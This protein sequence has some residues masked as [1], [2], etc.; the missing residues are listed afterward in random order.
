MT[1]PKTSV[2]EA[3]SKQYTQQQSMIQYCTGLITYSCVPIPERYDIT[4]FFFNSQI[5]TKHLR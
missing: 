3:N 4:F 5:L 2:V 1:C